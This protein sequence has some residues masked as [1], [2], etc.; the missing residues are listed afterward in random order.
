[1]NANTLW[2][3]RLGFSGKQGKAIEQMGLSKFLDNSFRA[4]YDKKNPSF[5]DNSPKSLK[6]LKARRQEIKAS[7]PVR[8]SSLLRYGQVLCFSTFM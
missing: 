8:K 1:M 4:S 3:L 7:N 6:E 2:S 5:L